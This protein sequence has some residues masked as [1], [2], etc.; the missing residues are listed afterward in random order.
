MHYNQHG[1]VDQLVCSMA[2]RFIGAFGSTFTGYIHRLRGYRDRSLKLDLGMF[3]TNY[4]END[5]DWK[6][7]LY[8]NSLIADA[9][10]WPQNGIPGS[11]AP[12]WAR[13]WS[14]TWDFPTFTD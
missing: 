8:K 4:P 6:D 13:E 12:S 5:K 2:N 1:M 11:T 14:L 10:W 9:V 3:F 7:A